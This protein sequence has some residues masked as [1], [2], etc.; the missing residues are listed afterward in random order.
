[1]MIKRLTAM[2]KTPL[3]WIA[4]KLLCIAAFLAVTNHDVFGRLELLFA[5]TRWFTLVMFAGVWGL[6]LLALLIA[7]FQPTWRWRLVWAGVMAASSFAG[8]G[9]Y[10]ASQAQLTVFDFA[11]LL[12]A[13]D[14]TGR[15]MSAYFT[16]F[17]I[18]LIV[19]FAGFAALAMPAA[20]PGLARRW[21]HR[22]RLVPALPVA[23]ITGIIIWK[24]GGGTHALPQQ[25]APA[26]MG[27]VVA[28]K[29]AVTELPKRRA[30]KAAPM[31]AAAARHI[32]MLVDESI[33]PDYLEFTGTSK[34]TPFLAARRD[35]VINFGK[36][37]SANNCSHYS[38]AMLRLGA[39]ENDVIGSVT[40]SPS[41][42]AYAK[43]AGFRTVFIDAAAS[44]VKNAGSLQNFMTTRERAEIDEYLV[45]D[46]ASAP[47]LDMKLAA[48]IAEIQ[49]RPEPHFIYANKNGAHFPYDMSYPEGQ[50]AFTPVMSEAKGLKARVN[51]YRN[52]VRWSVDE[53]FQRLLAKVDLTKT[54]ILYT[55]DHGQNLAGGKVTHCA[56]TDPHPREG[57]VPMLVLSRDETLRAR[58]IAA[59]RVNRDRTSHFALFPTLIDMFGYDKTVLGQA[60]GP[61]LFERQTRQPRFTSGDIFGMFSSTV[62][63]TTVNTARDH[64]ER[65]APKRK[66]VRERVVRYWITAQA[67][68]RGAG[69]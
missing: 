39:G 13:S 6:C 41:I 17:A 59:A 43:R 47:E 37:V 32:V 54:A 24:S 42:W 8:Y 38:N 69:R 25:F 11:S 55:S 18:A 16:Q 36:S 19:A 64:V 4:V 60:Y 9:Y 14:D 62:N 65:L 57:L 10:L 40:T 23:I 29:N 52:A 30:L 56:T 66:P 61:S 28:A 22:L 46:N 63:W 67:M 5:A 20:M 21:L 48:L 49:N 33:R 58:F 34:A 3:W 2:A 1:M 50:R 7:A 15:A 45:V 44:H 26:A 12:A 51:S 31:R 27:L 68:S 53:F 35:L